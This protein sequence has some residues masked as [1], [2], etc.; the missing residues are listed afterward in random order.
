MINRQMR[1]QVPKRTNM[2]IER[3]FAAGQPDRILAFANELVGLMPDVIWAA[4][5]R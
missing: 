1:Q 5:L 2:Q 4:A 3:R